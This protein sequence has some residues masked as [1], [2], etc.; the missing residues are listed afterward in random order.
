MPT[1]WVRRDIDVPAT[2]LP[3]IA[4]RLAELSDRER[5]RSRP[6]TPTAVNYTAAIDLFDGISHGHTT[7]RWTATFD[8]PD[9]TASTVDA[10]R[11]AVFADFTDQLR[12]QVSPERTGL[13]S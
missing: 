1:L 2:D 8:V 4:E 10:L 9:T 12:R 11:D 7:V 13:A 3:A 6:R 5:R